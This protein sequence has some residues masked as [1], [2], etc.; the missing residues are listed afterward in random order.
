MA[1]KKIDK[2]PKKEQK[3]DADD[4]TRDLEEII[5]HVKAETSALKKMIQSIEKKSNPKNK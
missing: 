4:A 3:Q 1:K 2:D 5:D